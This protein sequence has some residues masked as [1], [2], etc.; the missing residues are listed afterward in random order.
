MVTI[1]WMLNLNR[2]DTAELLWKVNS[3][4][5]TFDAHQAALKV[6]S[7]RGVDTQRLRQEPGEFTAGAPYGLR[8]AED[9]M[10]GANTLLNF[11][12]V[13]TLPLTIIGLHRCE[14]SNVLK[15][16]GKVKKVSH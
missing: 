15:V 14:S 10:L 8:S 13:V 4:L 12:L 5:L 9:R 1:D 2:F 16:E 7:E 11:S 6:L 3:S